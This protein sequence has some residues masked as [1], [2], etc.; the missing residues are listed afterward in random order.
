MSWYHHAACQGEGLELFFPVGT[1]GPALVQ[2]MN[3]K[4]L[5]AADA[6][7]RACV[8]GGPC[9]E[10]YRVRRV[11]WGGRG[12]NARAIKHQTVRG[13]TTVDV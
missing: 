9:V 12:R 8:C 7:S 5:S 2:L 4:G 11:G 10:R 3:A 13:G 6:W 1:T